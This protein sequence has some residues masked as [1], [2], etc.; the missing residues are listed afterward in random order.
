MLLFI[1]RMRSLM[2]VD[3]ATSA[4]SNPPTSLFRGSMIMVSPS[5]QENNSPS[6]PRERLSANLF[7]SPNYEIPVSRPHLKRALSSPIQKN[8]VEAGKRQFTSLS[9]GTIA[10]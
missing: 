10:F 7:S 5:H 2:P 8:P 4:P 1:E 3:A 9:Q 6:V